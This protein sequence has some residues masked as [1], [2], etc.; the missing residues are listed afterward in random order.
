MAATTLL[1]RRLLSSLSAR[2]PFAYGKPNFAAVRQSGSFFVDNTRFI[3]ELVHQNADVAVLH[4]PPRFGK[5][6]FLSTLEAYYDAA[7]TAE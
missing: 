1:L 3:R 7:N 5:S 4:R 6:L 2:S